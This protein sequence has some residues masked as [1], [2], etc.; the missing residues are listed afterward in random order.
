[1]TIYFVSS[2]GKCSFNTMSYFN[3]KWAGQQNTLSASQFYVGL[4]MCTVVN[5]KTCILTLTCF[6]PDVKAT[7]YFPNLKS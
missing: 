4:P 6:T 2:T 3:W 7:L 5:N 1:M